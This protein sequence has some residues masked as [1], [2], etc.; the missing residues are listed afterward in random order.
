MAVWREGMANV[1]QPEKAVDMTLR[2]D[3]ARALTTYPQQQKKQKKGFCRVFG[4]RRK[5]RK[6]RRRYTLT[7]AAHGPTNRVHLTGSG[8]PPSASIKAPNIVG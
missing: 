4:K 5:E 8:T 2:L 1:E 7:R 6:S 3:N